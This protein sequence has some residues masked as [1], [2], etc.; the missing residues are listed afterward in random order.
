MDAYTPLEELPESTRELFEYNP[1]KAKQLLDEAGYPGPNRFTFPVLCYSEEQIDILSIVKNDLAK[2]G[3]TL[4]IDVRASAVY[5]NMRTARTFK[6]SIIWSY[7]S[8]GAYS[9]IK[10]ASVQNA[11]GFCDQIIEDINTT[12]WSVQNA[13]NE[14]VRAA[15]GKAYEEFILSKAIALALPYPYKYRVWQPWVKNYHGESM[16]EGNNPQQFIW[17]DRDLK[18]EMTGRR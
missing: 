14:A 7:G 17:I 2:I 15:A 8:V 16:S 1:E 10:C 11:S 4:N 12:I 18:E 6:G 9:I 13:G 3:V 5:T